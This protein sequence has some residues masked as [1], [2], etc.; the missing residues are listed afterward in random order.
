MLEMA[1]IAQLDQRAH[2]L[3]YTHAPIDARH[4]EQVHLLVPSE[5]SVDVC[6]GLAKIRL[7]RVG[8]ETAETAFDGQEGLRGVRGV[9]GV[10]AGEELQVERRVGLAV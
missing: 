10:E 6:D 9:L 3:F 7:A 4:L 5:K 1:L 8:H 2:R